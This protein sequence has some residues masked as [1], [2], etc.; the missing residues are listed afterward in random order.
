[1]GALLQQMVGAEAFGGRD[2]TGHGEYFAILL[3]GILGREERAAS[4]AALN[5][6]HGLAEPADGPVPAWKVLGVGGGSHWKFAD[7][8]TFLA[9]LMEQRQVGD[10]IRVVQ[11]GAQHSCCRPSSQRPFVR[12]RIYPQR[13]TTDDTHAFSREFFRKGSGDVS[14]VVRTVPGADQGYGRPFEDFV[15][16]LDVEEGRRENVSRSR[17]G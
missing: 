17:V 1:V 7:D 4:G 12:A 2:G 16:T 11:T 3:Q 14:P 9:Y 8:R 13:H 15:I 10:R 5:D 6:D